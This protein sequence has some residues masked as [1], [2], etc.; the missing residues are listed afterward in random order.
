MTSARKYFLIGLAVFV[1]LRWLVNLPSYLFYGWRSPRTA[2]TL[3]E[4]DLRNINEIKSYISQG[5]GSN[6]FALARY[7]GGYHNGIDIAA[8]NG[9]P[10]ISPSPGKV[11]A[12]G[13]QDKFCPKR[14]YGRF[15]VIG[16]ESGE[17]LLFAHLSKVKVGIGDAVRE[18]D[19]IGNV[20]QTG[21]A[22]APHLH[23][24]VFRKGTFEMGKRKD[25][26]PNPKGENVNPLKYLD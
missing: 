11:L 6:I 15:A 5:Y 26:G 14:N 13:D 20:G 2:D 19:V 23:F 18:G 16:A 21:R 12:L 7:V 4:V 24:T 17:A 3:A 25:C 9:A 22:T 1:G 8:R 10:V